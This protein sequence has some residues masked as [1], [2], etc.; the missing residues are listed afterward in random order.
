MIIYAQALIDADARVVL[1]LPVAENDDPESLLTPRIGELG[2]ALA[3]HI[4]RTL[5]SRLGKKVGEATDEELDAVA[6]AL[7]AAMDLP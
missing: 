4:E 7:R 6:I 1:S 3:T 5:V 2:W